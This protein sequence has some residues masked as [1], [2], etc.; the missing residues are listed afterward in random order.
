MNMLYTDACSSAHVVRAKNRENKIDPI[1]LC[2]TC[3]LIR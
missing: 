1:L 2:D 3:V